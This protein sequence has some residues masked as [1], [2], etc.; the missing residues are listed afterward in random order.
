[1]GDAAMGLSRRRCLTTSHRRVHLFAMGPTAGRTGY[2]RMI[3]IQCWGARMIRVEHIRQMY[4][5]FHSLT[6]A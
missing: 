6:Q 5:A 4:W 2:S 3:M 1:M